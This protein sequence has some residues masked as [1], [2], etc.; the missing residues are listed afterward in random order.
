MYQFQVSLHPA[1]ASAAAGPEWVIDGRAWATLA[2]GEAER[3]ATFARD[4]E[5]VAQDLSALPRMFWEPDGSFV[6]VAASPEEEWQVDGVAYE[7]LGRLWYLE[8]TGRVPAA[9]FDRL[10]SA[11][12]W[13]A[14]K[15]MFQVTLAAVFLD[16]ATF[17]RWAAQN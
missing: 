5:Q 9:E 12:G 7:R 2:V 17:R 15:L 3:A 1:A 14:E 13:P 11:V 10:L 8:L 4:I 16:E 6:W